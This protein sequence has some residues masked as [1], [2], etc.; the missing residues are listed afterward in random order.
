MTAVSILTAFFRWWFSS[1]AALAPPV[2]GRGLR[3]N[4]RYLV[5]DHAGGKVVF[6][7]NAG[8]RSRELGTLEPGATDAG[9][10]RRTARR[11]A[12]RANLR[13]SR[14]AVR[15]PAEK[16]LR[17]TLV[18]PLAAESDLRQALRYQ[19][20]RQTPFTQDEVYF[21]FRVSGRDAETERLTVDLTVVPKTVVDAAVAQATG[22]GLEP[23]IVDVAAASGTASGTTSGTTSGTVPQ[24]NLIRESGQTRGGG[25]WAVFNA[26]LVVAT[27]AFLGAAVYLP[28]ERYRGE[29]EAWTARVA[30]AR[31]AA[32]E[33]AGLREETE[34]L[35]TE[36]RFLIDR[37]RAIPSALSVLD[38]LT[39]LLPDDTWVNEVQIKESGVRVSGYSA[40]ASALVALID[41][42]P[43]F[44]A[45]GFRSPVTQDARTGLERFTLA[46]ELEK[47]QP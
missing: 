17:K 26:M 25:G 4:G 44:K 40:A 15:L 28:L 32:Q 47:P 23:D 37:K 19:I 7:A 42:A 18:L 13:K 36:G 24:L 1:L 3:R 20:D 10:L 35:L 45:P 39:R 14:I 33:V 11:L 34:R 46:F 38:E 31:T 6:R 9:E 21:D 2:F 5:L 43:G 12:R 16:G 27:L 30:A 41:A 22:W 29:S 8:A